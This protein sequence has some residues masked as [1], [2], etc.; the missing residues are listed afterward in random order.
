M[1]LRKLADGTKFLRILRAK[2]DR[3]VTDESYNT[4]GLHGAVA[5]K[6]S[7]DPH[8]VV[9][10]QKKKNLNYTDRNIGSSLVLTL[11]K[12]SWSHFE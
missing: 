4:E 10:K 7:T 1:R 3:R 9:N 8:K 5:V 12:I 2:T 11:G 6:L